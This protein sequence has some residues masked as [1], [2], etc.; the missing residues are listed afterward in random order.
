MKRVKKVKSLLEENNYK[1]YMRM[2][3]ATGLPYTLYRSNYRVIIESAFCNIDFMQNVMSNK[4]FIVGAMIKKDIKN[5]GLIPP[6][7][8]KRTLR[9]YDFA[10]PKYLQDSEH[11]IYNIDI[12]SAYANVLYTHGIITAKTSRMMQR[13]PKKDRLAAVGMLASK[14]NIFHMEGR[15]VIAAATEEKDTANWFLFCVEKT[16][17]LMDKC[18]AILG[19]DFLFYWVDGIF[20]KNKRNA[21][22]VIKLIEQEGYKCSFDT[23]HKFIYN[24]NKNERFLTYW[25]DTEEGAE[26]KRLSLPNIN[27]EV[28]KF[29]LDF[30]KEIEK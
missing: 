17:E 25:K 16:A 18:R 30:L 3:E 20:F 26:Y 13:L 27:S 21:D 12:K 24:T 14:K 19:G 22:K 9:Y 2:C 10:P 28:D 29:I 5:T 1:D 15:K 8:D 4:A 7:I 6:D 23:C 11:T